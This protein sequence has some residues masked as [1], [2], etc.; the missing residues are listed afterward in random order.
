MNTSSRVTAGKRSWVRAMKT[1]EIG[2]VRTV[3]TFVF[4]N[5]FGNRITYPPAQAT[6][7]LS[8][9][10]AEVSLGLEDADGDSLQLS[11][12]FEV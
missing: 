4:W 7:P 6:L 1:A 3:C 10:E 9:V 5:L 2:S 12:P 11:L 8:Q